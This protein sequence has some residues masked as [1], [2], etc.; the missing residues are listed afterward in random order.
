MGSM[1]DYTSLLNL[2]GSNPDTEHLPTH[3]EEDHSHPVHPDQIHLHHSANSILEEASQ[4]VQEHNRQVHLLHHDMV[5]VKVRDTT[6][7]CRCVVS[8]Q[9]AVFD[10]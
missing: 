10:A 9:G 8:S 5:Q 3:L 4:L 7:S 1:V 6:D 2:H